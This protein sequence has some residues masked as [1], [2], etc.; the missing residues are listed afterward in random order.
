M[1]V[2]NVPHEI[3]LTIARHLALKEVAE[4]TRVSSFFR[5]MILNGDARFACVALV[6]IE[7]C[8]SE[9]EKD[10]LVL[11]FADTKKLYITSRQTPVSHL[12]ELQVYY[13]AC[14]NGNAEALG[15]FGRVAVNIC[16]TYAAQPARFQAMT[17][18]RGRPPSHYA[19]IWLRL[20][21]V[22]TLR[23]HR[24]RAVLKANNII[25]S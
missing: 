5:D 20:V 6:P 13:H 9:R 11:T 19:E 10:L 2:H 4:L 21:S 7:Q 16:D 23:R 3:W 1:Q 17:P 24:V 25:L 22:E 14:G 15:V 12:E 8:Y 18:P